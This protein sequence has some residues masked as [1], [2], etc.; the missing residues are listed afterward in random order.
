M[1]EKE[2]EDGKN[3]DNDKSKES[4][5]NTQG[6]LKLG[7]SAKGL[8]LTS[9]KNNSNPTET[10]VDRDE[11]LR[12]RHIFIVEPDEEQEMWEKV[13]ERKQSYSLPPRPPR[14]SEPVEVLVW[15]CTCVRARVCTCVCA[16][17]LVYSHCV[18]WR[19][20]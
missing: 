1:Q 5:L 20:I 16:Y 18:A 8:S 6:A 19:V 11:E 10:F 2:N 14:G 17:T 4:D 13:N 12:R 15:V 9:E 3:A 7:H